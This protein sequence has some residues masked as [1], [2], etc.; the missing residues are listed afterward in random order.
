MVAD[1]RRANDKRAAGIRHKYSSLYSKNKNKKSPQGKSQTI[2]MTNLDRSLLGEA[3]DEARTIDRAVERAD[4]AE[5][6]KCGGGG[7]CA[8]RMMPRRD[9]RW[10]PPPTTT[11]TTTTTPP[12][13]AHKQQAGRHAAS[14]RQVNHRHVRRRLG[15]P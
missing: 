3:E 15:T 14:S 12:L 11:T 5:N 8:V 10:C 1:K 2:R 6:G 9:A 4:E 13:P 7:E